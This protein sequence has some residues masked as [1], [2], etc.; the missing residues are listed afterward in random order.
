MSRSWINRYD[1]FNWI[2]C[3]PR[4]VILKDT[5]EKW[6]E[7]TKKKGRNYKPELHCEICDF[8]VITTTIHDFV[9]IRNILGC[10]CNNRIKWFLKYDEFTKDCN[11]KEYELFDTEKDWIIGT[12][13]YGKFYKPKIRCK[14]CDTICISTRIED[15]FYKKL[16]NCSCPNIN[17]WIGKRD[18]FIE[19]CKTR[20]CELLDDEKKWLE[21]TRQLG[22]K[23]KPTMKCLKCNEIFTCRINDFINLELSYKCLCGRVNQWQNRIDEIKEECKNRNT[24]LQIDDEALIEGLRKEGKNFKPPIKCKECNMTVTSSSINVFMSKKS[25][26]CKCKNSRSETLMYDILNKIFPNNSFIKL[27]PNWLKNSD[28]GCNL[29]LDAYCDELKLAFEYNGRQHEEFCEFFHNNDT[30]NFKNQQ[31][32]DKKKIKLCLEHNIKL[33]IIPSKYN[34]QNPTEMEEFIKE[35]CVEKNEI[36][37]N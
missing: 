32:R 5:L 13:K 26:G 1:E 27:R 15:I 24:E 7:G 20:E 17:Q 28:T 9:G 19:I 12:K 22:R 33:I 3:I 25:L 36:D 16:L 37:S 11:K 18:K 8:T 6:I 23:Y 14:K 4:S 21:G 35:C 10:K 29:E 2:H 34:Y 31:L 30:E